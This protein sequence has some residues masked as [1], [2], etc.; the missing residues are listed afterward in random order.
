MSFRQWAKK[1]CRRAHGWPMT[2]TLFI[3]EKFQVRNSSRQKQKMPHISPLQ[4]R[5]I[6]SI[7]FDLRKLL[8]NLDIPLHCT[9]VK[10]RMGPIKNLQKTITPCPGPFVSVLNQQN[11][12]YGGGGYTALLRT[13]TFGPWLV[14]NCLFADTILVLFVQCQQEMRSLWTN[15]QSRW[16]QHWPDDLHTQ[17]DTWGNNCCGGLVFLFK[18]LMYQMFGGTIK[19]ICIFIIFRQ[20]NLEGSHSPLT[21]KTR[22]CLFFKVEN[23]AIAADD[24]LTQWCRV[25][26]VMLLITLV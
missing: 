24:F 12:S 23:M 4:V 21:L 8:H 19:Y 11:V 15:R 20:S 26:A 2:I 3:R 22:I 17:L 9:R 5:Y 1:R 18:S 10:H 16:I 6:A 13:V 7:L 14:P 25:S